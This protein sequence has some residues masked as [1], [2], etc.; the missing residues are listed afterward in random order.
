MFLDGLSETTAKTI[1]IKEGNRIIP[2]VMIPG[3][4]HSGECP[5]LIMI[6]SSSAT[7]V[8]AISI[9]LKKLK[10]IFFFLA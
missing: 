7:N 6:L 3:M 9:H 8:S 10:F 4:N 1:A 5:A 2:N